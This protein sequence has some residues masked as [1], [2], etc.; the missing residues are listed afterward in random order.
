M[1]TPMQ[2]SMKTR[3]IRTAPTALLALVPALLLA[4]AESAPTPGSPAP[5]NEEAASAPDPGATPV[6]Y[7]NLYAR[8]QYWP[9]HIRL[10][11]TW[12]PEGFEGERFGYGL[13]VLV[14]VEADGDLRVDFA[15]WGKHRVP[16]E[17]T[18]VVEEANRIR[19]GELRKGRP[20]FVLAVVNKLIDPS[21]EPV[22]Y[23]KPFEVDPIRAFLIVAADPADASFAEL[24]AALRPVHERPDVMP[25]FFPQ[26]GHTDDEV[27][28]HIETAGWRAPF[29]HSRFSG[30]Y[31]ASILGEDLTLPSF[32]LQTPEG[33]V[34]E[35]GTWAAGTGETLTRALDET[36]GPVAAARAVTASDGDADP[37]RGADG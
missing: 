24:T 9:Y 17:V 13:G 19:L 2:K 18:N 20:N 4:C 1:K 29:A 7:A 6:T 31:T 33:R 21:T 22:E 8:E 5:P 28:E 35:A 25:V 37:Q 27:L 16:A 14:R 10:T 34:I 26:G 23:V 36:L 3:P 30:P 32:V 15:R 12:K 11:E